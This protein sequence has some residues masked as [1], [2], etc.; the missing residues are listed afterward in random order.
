MSDVA[1][2]AQCSQS[3][4]SVVLNPDSKV[5]ISQRHPRAHPQGRRRP[6]ATASSTPPPRAAAPLRRIAVVF[7][8]L[9]V[10]PEAVIAVDGVREFTWDT[11]D[12]VSAYNCHADPLMEERTLDAVLRSKPGGDHLR[13][14][15]DAGGRGAR[16]AL[17][18]R[19]P[20]RPAQLLLQGPRLSRR[21]AGRCRRRQPRNRTPHRRGPPAHRPHHGR[22]VD[23]G[24]QGPPPRLS[25]RACH[26]RPPV[27]S[28]N[29]CAKAIGS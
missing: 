19:R 7:D 18:D 28:A 6:S 8:D 22:G 29:S 16:G 23:G 24:L 3:T 11:G 26:R 2:L 10:C 14:G 1:N 25:R 15:A 12:I 20:G 5:K 27:R 13:D 21:G 17:R 4:V 9:T